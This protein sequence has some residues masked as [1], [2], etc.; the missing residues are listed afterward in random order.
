MSLFSGS[1][2]FQTATSILTAAYPLAAPSTQGKEPETVI[3]GCS[4]MRSFM[5]AKDPDGLGGHTGW[6]RRIMVKIAELRNG[7]CF[8]LWIHFLCLFCVFP[9]L[10]LHYI[11]WFFFLSL[12]FVGFVP[13]VAIGYHT[14]L[15]FLSVFTFFSSFSFF[16]LP[17]QNLNIH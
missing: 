1:G 14:F 2:A 11:L 16:Q 6:N 5:V 13:H 3:T 10:F 8:N 17:S 4:T 7:G 15:W 9:C 12:V